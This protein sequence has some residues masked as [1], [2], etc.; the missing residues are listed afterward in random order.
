MEER[1]TRR[2]LQEEVEDLRTRNNILMEKAQL[3]FSGDGDDSCVV[4]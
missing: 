1:E 2:E 4:G 3:A